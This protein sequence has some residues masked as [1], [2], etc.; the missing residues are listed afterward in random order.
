[1]GV[2]GHTYCPKKNRKFQENN[3]RILLQKSNKSRTYSENKIKIID[4]EK[5]QSKNRQNSVTFHRL[6]T[7]LHLK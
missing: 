7:T 1:M 6:K 2:M 3:S 5:I 4:W